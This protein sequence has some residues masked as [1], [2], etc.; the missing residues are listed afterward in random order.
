MKLYRDQLRWIVEL[1]TGYL[2]PKGTPLQLELTDDPICERCLEKVESATR[3]FATVR[4]QPICGFVTWASFL[5]R[6]TTI[7]TPPS[8]SK[9]LQFI[10]GVGVIKG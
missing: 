1:L 7:I 2:S 10:R 9:V 3:V 4:L 8:I 5:L 6:Q